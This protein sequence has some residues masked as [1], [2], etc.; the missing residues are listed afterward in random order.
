MLVLDIE[1]L[2]KCGKPFKHNSSYTAY[3]IKLEAQDMF[4]TNNQVIVKLLMQEES[5]RYKCQGRR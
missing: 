3:L 5:I 1:H 2:D 4:T